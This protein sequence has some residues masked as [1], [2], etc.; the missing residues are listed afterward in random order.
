MADRENY[1]FLLELRFNPCENS[2]DVINKAISEKQ[3]KWSKDMTNPVKKVKAGEYLK[4]LE[5]IRAVMLN[6]D[7]RRREADDAMKIYNSKIGEVRTKVGL[8]ASK[9]ETLSDKDLKIILNNYS[10]F[11]FT[12]E[13]ILGEFQNIR[14]KEQEQKIN[15]T[16]IIDKNIANNIKRQLEQIDMKGKTL[17]DLLEMPQNSSCS[18]LCE[19]AE[20]MKKKILAKGEKTSRDNAVQALC[21]ICLTLFKDKQSKKKYDNYIA[22]TKYDK[23]NDG[24]DEMARA[25]NKVIE[26]QIKDRLVDEACSIY[27]IS[28]SDA[29][30]YISNYI[31]LMGYQE[32]NK[33]IIC[34]LCGAENPAGSSTCVK[35]GKVL[36]ITCPSCSAENGNAVKVCS[37][38]GFDFANIDK[39]T[40][41]LKEAKLAWSNKKVA[42]ATEKINAAKLL[43][44]NHPEIITLDSTIKEFNEGYSSYITAI[45]GLINSKKFYSAKIEIDKA[46]N[47][48]YT[49]PEDIVKKVA[50]TIA[51]TETELSKL[52]SVSSDDAFGILLSL[53]DVISDCE[54]VNEQLS[55]HPP[56]KPSEL[57]ISTSGGSIVISW[58]S[59]PSSGDIGYVLI[60]KENVYSNNADDG[61]VIYSGKDMKYFDSDVKH[62]VVYCYSVFAVRAGVTS[63]ACRA[64]RDAVIVDNVTDIHAV[65]GDEM[66]TLSW[67]GAATL[68]RVYVGICCS[69]EQPDDTAYTDTGCTRLDGCTVNKLTNSSRYWFKIVAYHKVEGNDYASNPTYV[70]VIPEKPA[71]PVDNLQMN[72]CDNII[73]AEWTN[74]VWDVV[75]F[76]SDK[77]PGYSSGIVY[78][79]DEIASKMKKINANIKSTGEAEF[80]L[81]FVGECYIVLA[82]INARNVVLND[83]VYFS[84]VPP[85][86]EVSYDINSSGSELYVNFKWPRKM[87]DSLLVYRMDGYPSGYDDPL[88]YIVECNKKQYTNNEGILISN[89]AQG[90]FFSLIYT[91]VERGGHRIYSEPVKLIINNEP[92]REVYYSFKLKKALF[93]KKQT[94]TLNIRSEGNFMLPQFCIVGKYKALPLKRSDGDVICSSEGETEIKNTGRLDF[95]VTVRAD[96]KLKMFFLNEKHYKKYKLVN[97]GN[98][99]F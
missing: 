53:S 63:A 50:N 94:L 13:Y 4:D 97:E 47:E 75:F 3:Q 83:Y 52:G 36:I 79:Y 46:V 69:P 88:A 78:D 9:A 59:S 6:G 57:K 45:T 65:G 29:S 7:T 44:P 25:N 54:R 14:K 16:E 1:F 2:L 42:A 24:I 21:G 76:Y 55:K 31:E 5:N 81:D 22:I 61:K 39:A 28:P 80:T 49:L 26:P 62:S 34:G 68:S 56:E 38:C 58:G 8:Y 30:A 73:K 98:N 17:Y 66:V 74:S 51:K 86:E 89:P 23:V 85:V 87:T 82:Q 43:W 64:D 10:R 48:G 19:K 11:G 67:Q 12:K 15:L 72:Y 27:K 18:D 70:N 41:L 35:C 37:K 93:G 91:Y 99:K 96:S 40:E 32:K 92:Q 20:Q 60:R 33:S 90:S 95:E 71:K 84:S 77:A